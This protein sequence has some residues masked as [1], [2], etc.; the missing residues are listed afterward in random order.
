MADAQWSINERLGGNAGLDMPR[1][2]LS[3]LEDWIHV[4]N[5]EADDIER[6]EREIERK[7][8]AY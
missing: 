8:K 4:A 3:Y 1:L 5:A 7:N 2:G 6:L